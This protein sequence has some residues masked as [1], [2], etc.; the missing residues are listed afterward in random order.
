MKAFLT[1]S[2]ATAT[3]LFS[4]LNSAADLTDDG[5][6]LIARATVAFQGQA[7]LLTSPW[8]EPEIRWFTQDA[9][10]EYSALDL[11]M[12]LSWH[13][14]SAIHAH[15]RHRADHGYSIEASTAKFFPTNDTNT[16]FVQF[17]TSGS[18]ARPVMAL[19]EMRGSEIAKIREFAR[20][21]T[22]VD[23]LLGGQR[24]SSTALLRN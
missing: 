14:E 19:M 7:A 5:G 9:T 17:D 22:I 20:V 11:E 24:F 16:V 8:Q 6:D 10:Y 12:L 23:V 3:L 18:L 13:G 4:S 21:E 1:L 2:I 15:L